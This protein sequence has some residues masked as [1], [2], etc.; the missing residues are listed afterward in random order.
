MGLVVKRS[1][2][3]KKTAKKHLQKNVKLRQSAADFIEFKKQNPNDSYGNSDKRSPAGTVYA[4]AFPKMKHV[5]L[6]G[7][8]HSI[9]YEI[10]GNDL[11]LYAILN[12]NESGTAPSKPQI[13][14]QVVSKFKNQYFESKLLHL[15]ED[16]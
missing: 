16:D 14:K 9:W 3:F 11:R 12:H 8:D 2:Y 1:S 13:Q 15:L 10:V 5:H 7:G 4:K 6:I